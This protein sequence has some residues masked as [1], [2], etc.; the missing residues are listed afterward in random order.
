MF[1]WLNS[2]FRNSCHKKTLHNH[3]HTKNWLAEKK[4]KSNVAIKLAKLKVGNNR[5][6]IYLQQKLADRTG[7]VRVFQILAPKRAAG[8]RLQ[9]PGLRTLSASCS[10]SMRS[11]WFASIAAAH[12]ASLSLTN[13]WPAWRSS[14]SRWPRVAG[15]LKWQKTRAILMTTMALDT[16]WANHFS[17][18]PKLT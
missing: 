4:L 13:G 9:R 6:E 5:R 12:D 18:Q 11:K 1:S 3:F 10:F 8:S 17:T 15:T 2:F 7:L 16:N 14:S